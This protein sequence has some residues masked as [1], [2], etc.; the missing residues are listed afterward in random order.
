MPPAFALSQDQTLR[1]IS[2]R[3][4]RHDHQRTDPNSLPSRHPTLTGLNPQGQTTKR[5]SKRT[6]THQK[7]TSTNAP[8]RSQNP[9]SPGKSKPPKPTK[10]PD[11]QPSTLTR[12]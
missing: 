8:N 3:A 11:H 12:E 10:S 7:D 1:F 2:D 6:V 5:I 4:T 9:A